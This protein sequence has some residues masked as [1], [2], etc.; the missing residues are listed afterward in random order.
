M[1]NRIEKILRKGYWTYNGKEIELC[2][3]KQ[4]WDYFYEEGYEESPD[5]NENGYAFYVIFG[6]FKDLKNANRSSTCLSIE[7]AITLAETKISSSIHWD[8]Y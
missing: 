3:L 2:I 7:E 4:N 5:L 1:G 8:N 6:N